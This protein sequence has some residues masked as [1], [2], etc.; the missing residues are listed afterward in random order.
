MTTV[1]DVFAQVGYIIN[2][3]VPELYWVPWIPDSHVLSVITTEKYNIKF[4]E[5]YKNLKILIAP[6]FVGRLC[7]LRELYVREIV[8]CKIKGDISFLAGK[9]IEKITTVHFQSN[10]KTLENC[11]IRYLDIEFYEGSLNFLSKCPL[12]HISMSTY[13]GE[14]SP[15]SRCPIKSVYMPSLPRQYLISLFGSEI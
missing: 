12:E 15:I 2:Q 5:R 4:I 6:N 8:V 14:L 7:P 13:Y 9:P 11:P 1:H 10:P 3:F